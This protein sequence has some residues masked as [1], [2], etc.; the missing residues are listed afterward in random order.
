MDIA[1]GFDFVSNQCIS[2]N[3]FG[4]RN[5]AIQQL[6]KYRFWKK[7]TFGWTRL[8]DSSCNSIGFAWDE[9]CSSWVMASK[10]SPFPD[11]GR[12]GVAPQLLSNYRTNYKFLFW[13]WKFVRPYPRIFWGATTQPRN[14]LGFTARR[15][16]IGKNLHSK[17][18]LVSILVKI[19]VVTRPEIIFPVEVLVNCT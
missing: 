10:V 5:T 6:L 1:S 19:L 14:V 12:A 18:H 16:A 15:L 4:M 2:T 11:V 9:S 8:S 3:P 13:C 7:P 17:G